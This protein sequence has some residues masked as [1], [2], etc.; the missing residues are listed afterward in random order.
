MTEEIVDIYEKYA[1]LFPLKISPPVKKVYQIPY[2]E[3]ENCQAVQRIGEEEAIALVAK[4]DSPSQE[5]DS[6]TIKNLI[7]NAICERISKTRDIQV[8]KLKTQLIFKKS[9]LAQYGD[10]TVVIYQG[11]DFRVLAIGKDLYLCIDYMVMPKCFLRADQIRKLLPGYQF[12]LNRGFYQEGAEWKPARIEGVS[13]DNATLLTQTGALMVPATN[14]LPDIPIWQIGKLLQRKGLKIDFNREVKKLSLL[15]V[16]KPAQQR[17]QKIVDIAQRLKQTIFPIKIGEYTLDLEPNPIRL[18][19]PGF[20]VETDLEEPS[21]AFDHEDLTKRSAKILQGLTQF[22]SYEK[23][24]KEISI[25]IL[26]TKDK[27][28]STKSLLERINSGAD[29]YPGMAKTFGTTIKISSMIACN[30]T[31]EYEDACKDFIR[32][33]EFQK[34][35]LLFVYTPEEEGKASYDS[36]YYRVKKVLTRNGAPCQMVDEETLADPRYKDMNLALNIFAKAGYTPWVLDQELQDVDLFIGLSYSSIW[37]NGKIERMMAYVNVFDKFGRWKFYHGDIEAFPYKQRQEHYREIIKA[38]ISRHK[39]EHPSETINNIHIHYTQKI[40]YKDLQA[41][42]QEASQ[43]APGCQV[44]FIYINTSMPVRLFD[45]A[46]P[47]ASIE[48]RTYVITGENQFFM[49]TT[50]SNIFQ[51]KGMG[52]PK[53]IQVTVRNLQK[54]DQINLHTVAQHILSL[55][56]LNWASTKNFCLEPITT[57]YAG[58]ISYF[59]NVFMQDQQFTISERIR[60]KPWFL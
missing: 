40:A 3:I 57:K 24:K 27:E 17:F 41:I 13:G 25:V 30:E 53:I 51:Q 34:T 18:M 36:P 28:Q 21:S 16:D 10:K 5:A 26:T 56:R 44:F 2:S 7:R 19:L 20:D 50:G 8:R 38:S 6:K 58:D 22:G 55:T 59:M 42:D 33:P 37:R 29:L 14:F 12:C 15:T 60:D 48:R 4:P 9:S 11:C 43:A 52:T 46:A 1:N 54:P 23:P 39:A 47:D 49:S 35:D 31:T 32:K 45:K